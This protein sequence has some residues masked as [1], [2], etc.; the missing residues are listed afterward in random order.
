[1]SSVAVRRL[2]FRWVALNCLHKDEGVRP[3][4]AP[5]QGWRCGRPSAFRA[6]MMRPRR[7]TSRAGDACAG[8]RESSTKRRVLAIVDGH[9]VVNSSGPRGSDRWSGLSGPVAEGARDTALRGL[10]GCDRHS[11]CAV[12]AMRPPW[13]SP[14]ARND[15]DA[16][17]GEEA[18]L[19]GP[20]RRT[21]VIGHQGNAVC[22]C[23]DTPPCRTM[24]S[25]ARASRRRRWERSRSRGWPPPSSFPISTRRSSCTVLSMICAVSSARK[26][27]SNGG[28]AR[29][30][31]AA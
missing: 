27:L 7:T 13:R 22:D 15:A 2:P 30:G 29:G 17:V 4:R 5:G 20:R 10:L 25:I 16:G 3:P 31:R 19:A 21:S 23:N 18:D 8:W 24:S 1:M 11:R 12:P 14:R 6:A 9:E 28:C 26:G